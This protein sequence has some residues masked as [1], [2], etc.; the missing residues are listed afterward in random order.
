MENKP[1]LKK[2]IWRI[3]IITVA[4]AITLVAAVNLYVKK[5]N[6]N[7][8]DS[9][10]AIFV[11]IREKYPEV[12]YNELMDILNMDYVD[13]AADA[14]AA[15]YGIDVSD[16]TFVNSN[17]GAMQI[18]LLV[19]IILFVMEAAAILLCMLIYD[20]KRDK[21]IGEITRYIENINKKIYDLELESNTEDELSILKN[22]IGKTVIMLKEEAE[23]SRIAKDELKNS[24]SDISHQLKTP[25]TAI[26]IK[27]DSMIDTPDMSD[28][29]RRRFIRDIRRE[30]ANINFMV[31]SLLKLSR[32]DANTVSFNNEK[33]ELKDIVS[34]A[35]EHVSALS[36]LKSVSINVKE[37][38]DY[39]VC[40]DRRWHI[41][42]ISNI[43]KNSVEHAKAGSTVEIVMD[44]NH[45][46]T[47]L[48]ITNYGDTI[49]EKDLPH[50]FERFYKGRN[51]GDDSV[52]IGLALA[53]SIIE[54]SGGII[55]VYSAEGKTTFTVK[56]INH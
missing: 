16:E 49:S 34:E 19:C 15:I 32:L 31:Q 53:R 33:L 40:C 37:Q 3:G 21:G 22:E 28:G 7:N 52:G 44:E 36:D 26:T 27:L 9:V 55:D 48:L 23:N 4:I 8:N 5:Y 35:V 11:A 39:V 50:V 18:L 2:C 41:E 54:S 20:R 38:G 1:N 14:L 25:L 56:W 30:T 29:D 6:Y 42:A 46:F 12:T 13:G 51:S 10:A 43:L 24:L 47:R 17:S 45:V